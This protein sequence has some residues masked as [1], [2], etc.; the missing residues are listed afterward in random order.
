ME[1][2]PF[3]DSI[4]GMI[5][6]DPEHKLMNIDLKQKGQ[7]P[8]HSG[9]IVEVDVYH[10]LEELKAKLPIKVVILHVTPENK[11]GATDMVTLTEENC[12]E[13]ILGVSDWKFING[14]KVE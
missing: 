10:D 2:N 13:W 11:S 14:K 7:I 8:L 1:S 4:K 9:K 6:L 12:D 5:L 3:I